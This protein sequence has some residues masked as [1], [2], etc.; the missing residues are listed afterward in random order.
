MIKNNGKVPSLLNYFSIV[1]LA[2]AL[3]IGFDVLLEIVPNETSKEVLVAALGAIFVV[4]STKYLMEKQ[5]EATKSL[6]EKESDAHME[7]ERRAVLFK[8]NLNNYREASN[9][10]LS[11]MQNDELR[12][13]EVYQMREVHARLLLLGSVDSIAASRNFLQKCDEFLNAGLKSENEENNEF[14]VLNR[15]QAE[16][17]WTLAIKFLNAARTSL[18]IL[19]EN[20]DVNTEVQAFNDL[21]SK[22]VIEEYRARMEVPDG[23]KGWLKYRNNYSEELEN[24][25]KELIKKIK[26]KHPDLGHKCTRSQISFKSRASIQNKNIFYISRFNKTT[27]SLLIQFVEK[28]DR[29]FVKD[30]VEDLSSLNAKLTERKGRYSAELNMP[31]DISPT[32]LASFVEVAEKYDASP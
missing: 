9:K 5:N 2:A 28:P 1:V 10:I 18:E 24:T 27:N 6:M 22:N 20:F 3:Y 13:Q 31:L 29:N 32:A 19:R 15:P 8:D 12:P 14:L 7:Q 30:R 26:E 25:I 4:L 23:I 16:E 11:I 17:L 21:N